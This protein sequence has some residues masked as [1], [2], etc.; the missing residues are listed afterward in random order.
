M[1][2]VRVGVEAPAETLAA[3]SATTRWRSCIFADARAIRAVGDGGRVDAARTWRCEASCEV[4][5]QQ[6]TA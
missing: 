6:Q 5:R 2:E 1:E 3:S 4:R